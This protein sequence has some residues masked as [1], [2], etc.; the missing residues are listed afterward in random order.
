MNFREKRGQLKLQE[1]S[2]VL[3]AL[4]IFFVLVASIFLT[5][6]MSSLKGNAQ[7]FKDD[8]AREAVR[9]ISG[10]PELLWAG[11]AGCIDA[12][13]ALVLKERIAQNQTRAD[14]WS[15][16]YLAIEWVYPAVTKAECTSANYPQ[17][18]T[19]TL[20]KRK[21]DYGIASSTFVSLCHW[22]TASHVQRCDLGRIIAAGQE[23]NHAQ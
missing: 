11:C 23:V 22:D 17:C 8:A 2:F 1:M 7:D 5:V 12:D 14:I 16:T 4:M 3:V 21:Q 13:K 9:K 19:L 20:I 6:R 18:N 10:S 15:F